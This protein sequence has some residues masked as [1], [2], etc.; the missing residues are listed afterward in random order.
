MIT[1]TFFLKTLNGLRLFR[2]NELPQTLSY[3]TEFYEN[4]NFYLGRL[5]R[6]TS[7]TVRVKNEHVLFLKHSLKKYLLDAD[8]YLIGSRAN[9]TLKG[10]Y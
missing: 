8:V 7:Q 4:K 10:G 9:D 3:N 5:N 1:S 2:S 6:G